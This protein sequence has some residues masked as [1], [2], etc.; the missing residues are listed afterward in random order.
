M[1][2]LILFLLVISS[3]FAEVRPAKY[4]ITCVEGYKW[5][6]FIHLAGRSSTEYVNDGLPV[7]IFESNSNS[8]GSIPIKCKQ[9]QGK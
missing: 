1:K 4:V 3:S 9:E 7:Q 2:Y 6:Q 8:T 5:V